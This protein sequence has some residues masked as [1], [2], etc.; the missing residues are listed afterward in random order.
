MGLHSTACTTMYTLIVKP[1]GVLVAGHHSV[2]SWHALSPHSS[3]DWDVLY[4]LR[5]IFSSCTRL[6]NS[7]SGNVLGYNI[8]RSGLIFCTLGKKVL[9]STFLVLQLDT[10]RGSIQKDFSV[11]KSTTINRNIGVHLYP[12]IPI[13]GFICILIFL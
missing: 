6:C 9:A 7:C 4:N 11:P 12:H 1:C 8:L 10:N 13:V 2:H 5:N 3:G